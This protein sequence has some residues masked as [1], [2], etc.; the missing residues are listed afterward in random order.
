MNLKRTG[1][2]DTVAY[3]KL[4]YLVVA[5]GTEKNHEKT[6]VRIVVVSVEI[7]NMHLPNRT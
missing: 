6:S 5:G 1:K 3:F 7:R 4:L 2:E